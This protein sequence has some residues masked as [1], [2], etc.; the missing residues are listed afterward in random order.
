MADYH[1]YMH[2]N[3]YAMTTHLLLEGLGIDYDVTWFDVHKPEEFPADF[4]AAEPKRP[5]ASFDYTE[6]ANLRVGGYHD[7]PVRTA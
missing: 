2:R 7:V 4:T 3:S 5:R 6:R 1:L